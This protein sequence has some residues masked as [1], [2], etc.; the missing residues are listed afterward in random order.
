MEIVTESLENIVQAHIGNS[1][2]TSQAT[3]SIDM[4]GF[5]C[6][7]FEV[8]IT[9]SANNAKA[10]LQIEGSD[11]DTTFAKLDIEEIS[12][13][14]AANDGLNKKVLRVELKRP[15]QRYLRARLL[16]T[17][18]NVAFGA[19]RALRYGGMRTPPPGDDDVV[20]QI[21]VASPVVA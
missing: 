4:T 15:L 18:A 6:A 17:V 7:L 8:D 16:S 10:E 3:D 2:S 5:V 21:V 1:N 19:T 12:A 14:A 9:D 20:A 11:D 13:T